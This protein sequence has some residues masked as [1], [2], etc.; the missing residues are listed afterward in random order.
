MD[1][2]KLVS[3][4]DTKMLY[5]SRAD[6]LGDPFEGSYP[7][8]NVEGRKIVP[9][10]LKDERVR[11]NYLA[12]IEN[13]SMF[14]MRLRKHMAVNGIDKLTRRRGPTLPNT[15]RIAPLVGSSTHSDTVLSYT[16]H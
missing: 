8:R 9:D 4:L 7:K 5:L 1:F 12:M 6:R 3:L 13:M 2:T 15:A 16:P 11:A 10:E 14:T